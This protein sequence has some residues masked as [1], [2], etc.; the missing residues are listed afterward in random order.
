[1][2][3]LAS[4]QGSLYDGLVIVSRDNPKLRQLRRIK[5]GKDHRALL[6][7]PHLVGEAAS[8]SVPLESI[9]ATPEFMRSP[10][11][12]EL[13]DLLPFSPIL[14]A[15]NLL[16]EIA[17]SDS[18]R[19][20]VGVALL[21]RG[22]VEV[23]E[24][25]SDSIVIFVDGIQ[26]PGNL[27]A[28]ARVA[29]ATGVAGLALAPNTVHPNHPRALRGSAGSLL[30]IPVASPVSPS[31]LAASVPTGLTALW[32]GLV[33][34][35]G[36]SLRATTLEPPLI[37]ALGSEGSGLSADT[38]EHISI[39]ISIPMQAP[40]ESLNVAVSAAVVLYELSQR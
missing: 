14:V 6:E 26:D 30:R 3:S 37:L 34:H 23:L 12:A 1:M 32:V 29:E 39:Q 36:E 40:V 31:D 18:P 4:T 10:A 19:G 5:R 13:I 28:L 2:V 24:W 25:S 7:G 15:G 38:R 21:E 22:G 8:A 11:A 35:G 17:D 16:D 27:G 20:I 33:P 9:L